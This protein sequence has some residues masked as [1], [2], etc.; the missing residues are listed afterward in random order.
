MKKYLNN[1]KQ[2]I[3]LYNYQEF[4]SDRKKI[5]NFSTLIAMDK[6]LP[7]TEEILKK[8]INLKT[9]YIVTYGKVAN[10]IHDYLDDIIV[11]ESST[12]SLF[13]NIVTD[14]HKNDTIEEVLEFFLNYVYFND[15][16]HHFIIICE[17]NYKTKFES[18]LNNLIER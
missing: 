16:I 6:F 18:Y 2:E 11:E 7:K 14:S 8:V 9:N 3:A 10:E 17:E 12:N 5:S 13:L 1:K 15:D 4:I